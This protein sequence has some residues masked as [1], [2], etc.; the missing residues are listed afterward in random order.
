MA[1]GL[2]CL[3]NFMISKAII[4]HQ[5][6]VFHWKSIR[7]FMSI[8]QRKLISKNLLRVT[9][10]RFSWKPGNPGLKKQPFTWTRQAIAA[11]WKPCYSKKQAKA[12]VVEVPV[13]PGGVSTSQGASSLFKFRMVGDLPHQRPGHLEGS[14]LDRL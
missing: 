7:P 10:R 13:G 12:L 8:Q 9:R 6:V 1:H 2:L 3:I 11:L 4:V 5:Y 14:W